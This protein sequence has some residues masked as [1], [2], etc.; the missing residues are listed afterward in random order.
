MDWWRL[1]RIESIL[2]LE[3]FERLGG[4]EDGLALVLEALGQ[5]VDLLQQS[6]RH[7]AQGLRLIGEDGDGFLRLRANL[8]GGLSHRVGIGGEHLIELRRLPVEGRLRRL[9]MLRQGAVHLGRA[10]AERHVDLLQ[11]LAERGGD[12]FRTLR[13]RLV[14]GGCLIGNRRLQR[15]DALRERIGEAVG[16][17][18][19]GLVQRDRALVYR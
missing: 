18:G 14:D 15:L 11:P 5:S 13:Q 17:L 8:I 1:S 12:G 16:A 19:K 10:R 6:A 9:A 4:G 3:E 7:L 2:L